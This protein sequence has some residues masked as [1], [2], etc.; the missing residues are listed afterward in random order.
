MGR[1]VG[2]VANPV[3]LE[4]LE[5]AGRSFK[6]NP[7]PIF[8][9]LRADVPGRPGQPVHRVIQAFRRFHHRLPLAVLAKGLHMEPLDEIHASR[10][11]LRLGAGDQCLHLQ[12]VR[13]SVIFVHAEIS[14]RSRER[15]LRP[16]PPAPERPAYRG[17]PE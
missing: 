9:R 16:H 6:S 1:A 12:L 10:L 14:R 17:R 13:W 7:Y 2:E 5:I 4:R 3:P 8:A 15:H 11:R